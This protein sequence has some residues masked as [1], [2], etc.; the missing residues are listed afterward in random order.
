MELKFKLFL[1]WLFSL[2]NVQIV[3]ADKQSHIM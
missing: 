3:L 2:F 1:K